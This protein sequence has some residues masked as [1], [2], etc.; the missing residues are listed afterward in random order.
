MWHRLTLNSLFCPSFY[1]LKILLLLSRMCGE[2]R[3]VSYTR[4]HFEKTD[5]IFIAGF[6]IAWVRF[7]SCQLRFGKLR[8]HSQPLIC[9]RMLA[10]RT[11]VRDWHGLV[12]HWSV[13]QKGSSECG[14]PQHLS[15]KV[16]RAA[17][18]WSPYYHGYSLAAASANFRK[19]DLIQP[20]ETAPLCSVAY[21]AI[22]NITLDS[23][24]NQRNVTAV[25]ISQHN[26]F[27]HQQLVNV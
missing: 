25:S 9:Q 8:S 24:T 23:Q 17:H 15:S 22:L 14:R 20:S 4:L 21:L 5:S 10:S 6:Q 18:T 19:Q 12:K 2:Y 7:V 11:S 13:G 16:N 27:N 26:T 3:N 1:E